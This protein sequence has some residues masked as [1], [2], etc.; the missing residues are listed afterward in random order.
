MPRGRRKGPENWFLVLATLPK[1]EEETDE[2]HVNDP[3]EV[4]GWSA[5]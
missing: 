3:E 4:G 5:P 1:V 2:E